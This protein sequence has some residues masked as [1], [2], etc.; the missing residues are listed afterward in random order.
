[1]FFRAGARAI[2]TKELETWLSNAFIPIEPSE[3]FVKKLKARLV[4]YH[5]KQPFSGWMIVGSFA[6]A[7]MLLLTWFGVALRIILLLV[8]LLGLMDRR[9]RDR[10][11]NAIPAT[12][13]IEI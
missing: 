2:S 3:V 10:S 8:S 7:L 13:A 6:M 5:G 12:G 4:R 1:M 9:K 11:A